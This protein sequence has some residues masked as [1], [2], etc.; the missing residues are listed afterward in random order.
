MDILKLCNCSDGSKCN[1]R[2]KALKKDCL[3]R[4]SSRGTMTWD[5]E[6][7]KVPAT[8]QAGY[9]GKGWERGRAHFE[10]AGRGWRRFGGVG[11]TKVLLELP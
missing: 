9:P 3:G 5:L 7:E 10:G 1:I 11:K 8:Q 2:E 4:P 6:V